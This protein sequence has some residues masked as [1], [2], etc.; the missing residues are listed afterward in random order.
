[1]GKIEFIGILKDFI[2]PEREIIEES[3]ILE[4]LDNMN[5]MNWLIF[6]LPIVIIILIINIIKQK[7]YG[8]LN[9]EIRNQMINENIKKYN[10]NTPKRKVLFR[11]KGFAIIFI[12]VII[13]F[14]LFLLIHELLHGI[15]R[16]SIW[17]R[18]ANSIFPNSKNGS[19]YTSSA[20]NQISKYYIF[21]NSDAHFRNNPSNNRNYIISKK[22]KEPFYSLDYCLFK[23]LNDT[24]CKC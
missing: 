1:M 10:L 18:C 13:F 20:I 17:K 12:G 5:P 24:F 15:S 14:Y 21:N 6:A 8:M 4:G 2:L 9:K 23:L 11:L 19:S 7:K 3:H 16:S 22:N